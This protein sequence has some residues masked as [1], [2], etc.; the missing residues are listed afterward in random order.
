MTK[1]LERGLFRKRVVVGGGGGGGGGGGNLQ[2]KNYAHA[3][4]W[5]TAWGSPSSLSFWLTSNLTEPSI[6]KKLQTVS[7]GAI[8]YVIS[9]GSLLVFRTVSDS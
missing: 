9:G 5:L 2:K 4:M 3:H 7:I 1:P 6:V 8:N